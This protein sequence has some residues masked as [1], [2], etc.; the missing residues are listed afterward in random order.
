MDTEKWKATLDWYKQ[1]TTVDGAAGVAIA[2]FLTFAGRDSNLVGMPTIAVAYAAIFVFLL[3][4]GFSVFAMFKLINEVDFNSADAVR[5]F[6]A[7]LSP[8][9]SPFYYFVLGL[10]LFLAAVVLHFFI[11]AL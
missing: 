7:R 6:L 2:A 1:L 3:S 11:S 4:V 10:I 9:A 8:F 5:N